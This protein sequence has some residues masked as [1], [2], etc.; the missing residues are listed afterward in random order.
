MSVEITIRFENDDE[1]NQFLRRFEHRETY[2][3][4]SII[5]ESVGVEQPKAVETPS[6]HDLFIT[7]NRVP[8][9]RLSDMGFG[10]EVSCNRVGGWSLWDVNENQVAGE[11]A[12]RKNG[13]RLDVAGHVIVNSLTPRKKD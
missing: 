11:F 7:T 1:A 4:A 2:L 10:M 13:L 8:R 3:H 12:G 5:G 6:Y 9:K